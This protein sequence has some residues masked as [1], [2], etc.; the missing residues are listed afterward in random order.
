MRSNTEQAETDS[1]DTFQARCHE[2][3]RLLFQIVLDFWEGFSGAEKF[4]L[5]LSAG[6]SISGAL[7][8]GGIGLILGVL[9]ICGVMAN[10][11]GFLDSFKNKP[12]GAAPQAPG[13][14]VVPITV[15]RGTE[16]EMGLEEPRVLTKEIA[17]QFLADELSVDLSQFTAID[18]DAAE[19]LSRHAYTEE[20]SLMD[21]NEELDLSGLEV[22]SSVAAEHL[23]GHPGRLILN[24]L[25]NICD[26]AANHLSKHRGA[27]LGLNGLSS[28][29]DAAAI[30]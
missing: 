8:M 6:T 16:M 13:Q 7:G 18:D 17:Q 22:L 30:I 5:G 9:G 12:E 19:V 3:R 21:G 10:Q 24:G 11:F 15:T 28:I 2:I 23:S 25:D 29:S 26:E 4:F 27:F 1:H 14:S 20:P